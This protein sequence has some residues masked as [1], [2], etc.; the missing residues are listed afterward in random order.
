MCCSRYHRA[1]LSELNKYVPNDVL[2]FGIFHRMAPLRTGIHALHL[3]F[4]G[5]IFQILETVRASAKMPDM[6]FINFDIRHGMAPLLFFF[7]CDLDLF[8]QGQIFQCQYI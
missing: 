2:D 1:Y 5:D 3:I 6:D 4:Q 7:L 8:F